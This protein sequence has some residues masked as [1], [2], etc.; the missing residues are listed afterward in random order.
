MRSS[1]TTRIHILPE[2]LTNKI[3]AGEVVERPC[4]VVK[5]LVENS[6]D[7]GCTDI[8]VE[9]EGGG[10]RLIQVTDDGCGMSREDALLAL[11]RHAT[12]K[13]SDECDLFGISTL[14]FR[15]EALP[16]IAS[17]SRFT[18]ATRERGRVEGTEIYAEGGRIKEVK[19]CGMAEGTAIAVRNLFFNTPARLKFMRSGE[20]EAGHVGEFLTRLAVSRPDIRFTYINDGRTV[21]RVLQ[22]GLRDRIAAL[23]GGAL[24]D[25]LFPVESDSD[26]VRVSGLIA[27]PDCSRSAASHLYTFINGRFIRDRVVQHAVLGAYRNFLERGRYPVVVI[28]IEVPSA[29]VDVNVHPTK[30]EV[31]FRDQGRVHDAIQGA[32]AGVLASTPWLRASQG[33]PAPFVPSPASA[34]ETRVAEVREALA[35]YRP[36]PERQQRFSLPPSGASPAVSSAEARMLNVESGARRDERFM[37]R[38][39]FRTS[40][41]ESS[42]YFSALTVIGQFNAAYILCQDGS[43]LVIVDQHAAHERVAFEQLKGQHG[44]GGIES[45]GLL[46]PETVEL[47]FREATTLHENLAGIAGLGYEIEA[48]GGNAWLLKGVPRLLAERNYLRILLDILE[49]LQSLGKSRTFAEALEEILV[50]IACHSVVRGAH[51]LTPPEISALFMQ[52]DATDFS[53]NCPH[54]RPVYRKITLGEI[55]RMFKRQ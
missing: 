28:F 15:G 51:P 19:A 22:G 18:L 33:K 12:S 26:G 16:A 42:G 4:S 39:E 30:H 37:P 7:A 32:L 23:F 21:F 52:M 17:V 43:D 2:N 54:G 24:V 49:E 27:S 44:Q 1:V 36:E 8:V 14:G 31:R 46:F 11:E 55:E 50:R 25:T 38:S 53:S 5:E 13:I 47:S 34:T 48:F 10:K 40:H 29:E 35:R 41:A 45:Q 9:V 20:T 3:A 6:V